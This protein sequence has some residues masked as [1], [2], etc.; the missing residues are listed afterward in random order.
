MPTCVS[1]AFAIITP[2]VLARFRGR[3]ASPRR[4]QLH[5]RTAS[6]G[7][8]NRNRLFGGTRAMF[9]FANV[10][11]LFAHEFSCLGRGR[12]ALSL[13][14]ACSSKRLFLWHNTPCCSA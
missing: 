4:W 9:A 5:S 10:M 1:L 3:G 6:F 7:Q 11:D 14:P 12:F 13:V 2:G 8:S